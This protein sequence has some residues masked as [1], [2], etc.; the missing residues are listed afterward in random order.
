[1]IAAA[2]M[3]TVTM[4]F[5]PT[6]G[7]EAALAVAV[8]S[9]AMAAVPLAAYGA[10]TLTRRLAENG[11]LSELAMAFYALYAVATVAAATMSGLVGTEVIGRAADLGSAADPLRTYTHML[12]Q[13]FAKVVVAAASVAIGLW[14]AEILR[15]RA[16]R[17]GTGVF[18]CVVAAAALLA[19]LSGHL[20]LDVHGFGAVV[21]LQAIWLAAAGIELRRPVK[22][23]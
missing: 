23:T 14:S 13:G 2:V 6:R 7:G 15:T 10:W 19:L 9:L 8:H 16:M 4:A 1:M 22:R 17:R 12:N 18:G 5:H 3:G 20:R 21:L 11:P